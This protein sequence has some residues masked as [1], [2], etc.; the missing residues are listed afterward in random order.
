MFLQNMYFHTKKKP[1]KP[2]QFLP[3]QLMWR[4][5]FKLVENMH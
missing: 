2:K 4:L 1:N 5:G 3:V